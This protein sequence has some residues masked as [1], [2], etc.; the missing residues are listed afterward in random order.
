MKNIDSKEEMER[1]D[2][3]YSGLGET[4]IG[5]IDAGIFSSQLRQFEKVID[6]NISDGMSIL[7]LAAGDGEYTKYTFNNATE[8]VVTDISMKGL[9]LIKDFVDENNIKAQVAF[10]KSDMQS[11]PLACE[12]FD[13]VVIAKSLSYGNKNSIA[14]E[15]NRVLKDKGVFIVFD[16]IFNNPMY[17]F[18]RWVKYK[19]GSITRS[20]YI[21]RLKIKDLSLIARSFSDF[22]YTTYGVLFFLY[23]IIRCLMNAST[24]ARFCDRF[25]SRFPIFKSFGFTVVAVY[26][27]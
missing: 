13:V 1:Y 17:S 24:F 5:S 19:N 12:T 20:S 3:A 16:Q 23:P 8:N 18:N 15:V 11:L 26:Y 2:L 22:R 9:K 21:N 6:E 4:K 14:E 7:E 27:K 25:E 10:V